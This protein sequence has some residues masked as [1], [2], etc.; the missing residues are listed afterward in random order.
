M[1]INPWSQGLEQEIAAKNS[2]DLTSTDCKCMS[3]FLAAIQ[4]FQTASSVKNL[5]L[6]SIPPFNPSSLS[7]FNSFK[8]KN[9]S[10]SD[11]S[12]VSDIQERSYT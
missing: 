10:L 9:C 11:S 7:S 4:L 2:A 5:P 1:A 8:R 12:I 3:D 6:D